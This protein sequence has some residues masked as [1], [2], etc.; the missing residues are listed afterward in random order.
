[1][2]VRA[3]LHLHSCVSPCGR[4]ECSPRSVAEAAHRRGLQMLALTDHNTALNCP[5]FAAVCSELGLSAVFGIEITTREEVHVLG[6]F[7]TVEQAL[8]LG[9]RLWKHLPQIPFDPEKFGDQV[10]V[11]P[12]GVIIGEV[13][14]FLLTGVQLGL[15]ECGRL[16]QRLGGLFVPAHIDRSAY[17]IWS[18]L[19][20]LPD[21]PYDG[22]E[23]TKPNGPIDTGRFATLAS[24]DAHFLADVG[25]RYTLLPGEEPGFAALK[26]ALRARTTSPQ[27]TPVSPRSG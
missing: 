27:F 23:I 25:R 26:T 17:S 7:E 21:F 11:D 2:P 6:L 16:G 8:E 20:F 4:L 19:G 22:L 3:D 14:R 15:E 5:A 1:M 10:Y 13:E 24:S 18:Q 12:E 9:E